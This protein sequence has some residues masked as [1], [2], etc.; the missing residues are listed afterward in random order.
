MLHLSVG[1]DLVLE[2]DKIAGALSD[3]SQ[4]QEADR[5]QRNEKQFDKQKGGEQFGSNRSRNAADISSQLVPSSRRPRRFP[6]S[7]IRSQLARS[8]RTVAVLPRKSSGGTTHIFASS[9]ARFAH[10]LLGKITHCSQLDFMR[11]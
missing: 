7:H 6:S 11:S 8:S 1:V 9:R 3:F 5:A 2:R 4:G 10:Y